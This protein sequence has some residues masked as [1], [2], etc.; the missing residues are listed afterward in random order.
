MRWQQRSFSVRS[1]R[2]RHKAVELAA[3]ALEE[4]AEVQEPVQVQVQGEAPAVVAL[5]QAALREAVEV[6]HPLLRLVRGPRAARAQPI[7]AQR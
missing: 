1:L 7:L 2:R 5:A 6:T 4:R 3:E